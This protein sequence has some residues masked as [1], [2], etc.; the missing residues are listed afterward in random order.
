MSLY[1]Y[2]VR[3][4]LVASISN[5][6]D[7]YPSPIN[8]SYLWGFGSLA[9]MALVIQIV[10]GVLLAMH[11][12]PEVHLAFSSVEHIMRDVRGGVALRYIHANGASMFFIVVYIHMFRGLY[13]GSYMQPRSTLWYTGVLLFFLMMAAGFMGYV[14]PWGQM[15]FWGATVITNL[16]SAIPIVGNSIVQLLWGGFSVDNP[17]LN[18]FF[19]LHYLVP[20]LIAAA[21]VLHLILLHQPGGNNPLGVTSLYDRIPFYPY[22]YV[23]DLFGFV[24]FILF[25]SFFV[26]YA[27]NYL[28]HPDNYIEANPMVTPPHIVPEWY[29]LPFY[30]ILRTIPDKLG[31][32]LLMG[33]SILILTFLPA[34]DTSAFRSTFFKPLNI[35]LF[36]FF[37]CNGISLGWIGQEI[38]ESPF[39]E[40]SY[41]VT[42]FYFAYF[43]IFLPLTG[44]LENAVIN[45]EVNYQNNSANNSSTV[46][47]GKLTMRMA[48]T[49]FFLPTLLTQI[50]MVPNV[51]RDYAM[52]SFNVDLNF[53][54]HST[55]ISNTNLIY[56]G[57]TTLALLIL[58]IWLPKGVELTKA[59]NKV[60]A[61]YLIVG[62]V[63]AT[64]FVFLNEYGFNIE[65]IFPHV[66]NFFAL[67]AAIV[68]IYSIVDRFFIAH[69]AAIEF[70][71]IVFLIYFAVLLIIKTESFVDLVI[72]LETVTLA[73]YVLVAFDRW[74]RPGS[75]AS[76]EYIIIGSLPTAFILIS[77]GA[78]GAVAGGLYFADFERFVAY[79]YLTLVDLWKDRANWS[80]RWQFYMNWDVSNFIASLPPKDVIN[81]LG[82]MWIT[83]YGSWFYWQVFEFGF[84]NI[85]TDG[86][87]GSQMS[88]K[89]Y[90]FHM[91]P[92]VHYVLIV[93]FFML[94]NLLFKLTAAPFHFWAPTIYGK[95]PAAA[96]S[97]LSIMTKVLVIGIFIRLCDS[98][99]ALLS[100][101]IGP[102]FI[103][104]GLFSIIAGMIGAFVEKTIKRFYV[105]SS[106]GH[107]GFMLVAIGL[108]SL[109]GF[110]ASLHY[111]AI[112]VGSSYIMWLILMQIG[113]ENVYLT[114][115]KNIDTYMP[116]LG[117]MLSFMLFSMS[118]LPPL[119]GFF[120]KLD[121]LYGMLKSSWFYV[122]MLMFVLT[123]ATFF[124][125][126]RIIKII[127]FDS[128][129]ATEYNVNSKDSDIS[130]VNRH[131]ALVSFER[132]WT[133]IILFILL[134]FYMVIIQQPLL[135][136]IKEG[137]ERKELACSPGREFYPMEW[138]HLPEYLDSWKAAW[139][140]N[141]INIFDFSRRYKVDLPDPMVYTGLNGQTVVLRDP[142]G[143]RDLK[144]YT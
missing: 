56:V 120:V 75:M 38:V 54:T 117:L 138:N 144:R 7:T 86:L 47:N 136:I 16:F 105:Y 29:F 22:Y 125:Y 123:V 108:C 57:L 6:I 141:N 89:G 127:F 88:Q 110:I 45:S 142:F 69:S 41:F 115:F 52:K 81:W 97:F 121:I 139:K 116:L 129:S 107:V 71:L 64:D 3:N 79:K 18:R 78:M 83:P 8:F 12:A 119:A 14:L 10:S 19:S 131:P 25:F 104:C 99:W 106:M 2:L 30:A 58:S 140:K 90:Y 128:I 85:R 59:L 55:A 37:F 49:F 135:G 62:F 84:I 111:L 34:L 113:R 60:V 87:W 95:A 66:F 24:V 114:N 74:N 48:N 36:W 13:Y 100:E 91:K 93:T 73:S 96:A 82:I 20:F 118:G 17:T 137:M 26:I 42:F 80:P 23:K 4:P 68:F 72:A 51:W 44:F 133:I 35:W 122:G 63:T 98:Y 77:M 33:L 53:I 39:I 94:V 32:V 28:G 21:A 76:I 61:F 103:F 70:P 9:G 50:F 130:L 46:K 126:L 101:Y 67:F 27:P 40:M 5:H 102:F 1:A 143:Y 132:T 65:P 92:Y 112:Y 124:Y 134:L 31:G 109:Q 11:Y 15:S 43:L